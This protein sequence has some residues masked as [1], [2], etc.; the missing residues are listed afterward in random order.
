MNPNKFNCGYALII[1]VGADLPVTVQDATALRDVLVNSHR[2]AYPEDQVTLLTETLADRK[3]V[4]DS[5]DYLIKRTSQNPDSTVIIYYSGHGGK[6]QGTDEY[7]IVPFAYNSSRH[8]ETAISGIEFT[9]RIEAI[10]ARKLVVI[11]DCCHAGGVP[12]L[13]EPS[14]TFI[15]SPVP[16]DLLDMLG[17]GTGRVVIASSRE[18][19]MSYT[20]S[21][22]SAFTACLLEAM[23]GKGTKTLDGYAK[24]LDILVY[25][26]DQVPKRTR[27]RQHPFVKKILDLG[28]NFPLCYYAG[29][30]KSLPSEIT[31]NSLPVASEE[32]NSEL[33]AWQERQLTAERDALLPEWELRR[34][35]V[36]RM[37]KDLAI[38]AGTAVK[39]QLEQQL[40]EEEV[41]LSELDQKIRE[42]E[43]KING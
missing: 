8:T 31:D 4:L 22:Y 34:Q 7:F 6:I 11:L 24:I 43:Q 12:A 2:A 42:I 32:R 35:K 28:D 21:P 30:S 26:F 36:Q 20:G 23:Q 15:K 18:D 41:K 29:G 17:S 10:K 3:Q 5:F 40:L 37:R 27:D 38:E 33:T 39:F 9:E 16:P 19:E 1:G 14:K 25:L 13:K